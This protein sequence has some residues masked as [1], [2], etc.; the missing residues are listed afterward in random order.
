MEE[1]SFKLEISKRGDLWVAFLQEFDGILW[2]D[3]GEA[4]STSYQGLQVEM[5][6][7]GFIDLINKQ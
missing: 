6:N 1:Q 3:K 7:K 5:G 4:F 2:H